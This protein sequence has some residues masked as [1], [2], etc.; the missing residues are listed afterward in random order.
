MT[1]TISIKKTI[2]LY[3][4]G[5][6]AGKSEILKQVFHDQATMF[7]TSNGQLQGGAIQGL[8]DVVDSIGAAPNLKGHIASIDVNNTTAT[9]RVE[10][11]DWAGA[12]YTDQLS[13]LNLDGHWK[14]ISKVYH[15]NK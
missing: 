4:E 9:A 12:N 13:L 6:I 1:N 15:E 14:I 2:N 10:L 7:F 11:T 8:Y 5:G 3:I